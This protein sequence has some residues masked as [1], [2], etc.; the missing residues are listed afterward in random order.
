MRARFL[1]ENNPT[2]HLNIFGRIGSMPILLN[3]ELPA[4]SPLLAAAESG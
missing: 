2:K 1:R 3:A 4:I